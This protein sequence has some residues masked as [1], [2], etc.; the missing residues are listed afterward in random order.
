M[1]LLAVVNN[2]SEGL[3]ISSTVLCTNLT[4][5]STATSTQPIIVFFFMVLR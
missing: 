1:T 4:F 3:I 5:A 2:K